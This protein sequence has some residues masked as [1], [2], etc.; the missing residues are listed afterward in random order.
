MPAMRSVGYRQLW[1]WCE[2]QCTLEQAR[3]LAVVATGQLAK[4]QLTWLR[5]EPALESLN[6]DDRFAHQQ[7]ANSLQQALA[8]L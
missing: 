7:I 4:R 5:S 8:E 3:E 1:Q 2:G 6:A